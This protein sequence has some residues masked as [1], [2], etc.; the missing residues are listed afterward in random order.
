M[1]ATSLLDLTRRVLAA[2]SNPWWYYTCANF[3]LLVPDTQVRVARTCFLAPGLVALGSRALA[4]LVP[5]TQV[6]QHC[7]LLLCVWRLARMPLGCEASD[8][9]GSWAP[10]ALGTKHSGRC[11]AHHVTRTHAELPSGQAGRAGLQRHVPARHVGRGAAAW[12]LAGALPRVGVEHFRPAGSSDREPA[13]WRAGP[14]PGESSVKRW[15]LLRRATTSALWCRPSSN[16]PT[17]RLRH[18]RRRPSR[19]PCHPRPPRRRP[20]PRRSWP[21]RR[22]RRRATGAAW[23]AAWTP[24]GTEQARRRHRPRAAAATAAEAAEA[25]PWRSLWV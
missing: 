10:P 1:D 14:C 6:G 25:T 19:P 8:T 20:P 16:A 17:W 24:A 5:D 4:L 9:P 23:S 11:K 7:F 22:R 21:S 15:C 3:A 18:R 2:R 12:K 13:T